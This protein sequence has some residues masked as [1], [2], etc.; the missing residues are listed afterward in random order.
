MKKKLEKTRRAVLGA[1]SDGHASEV[2]KPTPFVYMDSSER[3]QLS[4]MHFSR[5]HM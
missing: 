1:L 3:G 2:R 5:E 4:I